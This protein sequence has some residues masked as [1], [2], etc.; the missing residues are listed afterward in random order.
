MGKLLA[1]TLFKASFPLGEDWTRLEV[2]AAPGV[3]TGEARA[4]LGLALEMMVVTAVD[5]MAGR[6]G[7]EQ[8]KESYCDKIC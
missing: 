8:A 3:L 4:W 6:D 1:P 5:T 7:V 2:E